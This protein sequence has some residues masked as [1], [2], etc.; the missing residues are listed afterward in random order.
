MWHIER[1]KDKF[2]VCEDNAA[3]PPL[4]QNNTRYEMRL[5]SIFVT[6]LIRKINGFVVKTRER[7]SE[8]F[9]SFSSLAIGSLWDPRIIHDLFC[10]PNSEWGW[11]YSFLPFLGITVKA[12]LSKAA[13]YPHVQPQAQPGLWHPPA[14][15]TTEHGWTIITYQ[16]SQCPGM[17]YSHVSFLSPMNRSWEVPSC[18]QV[19]CFKKDSL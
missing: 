3:P 9:S 2:N 11:Q 6:L 15:C 16:L 14:L 7:D 12:E 8:G 19:P 17:I 18:L 5:F 10:T 4:N 1:V 13:V